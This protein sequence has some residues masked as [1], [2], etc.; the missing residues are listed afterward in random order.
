[1]AMH[2]QPLYL[3]A[4]IAFLTTRIKYVYGKRS[5]LCEEDEVVLLSPVL[6]S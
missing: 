2:V 1:M 3:L 5:E 6:V 4:L